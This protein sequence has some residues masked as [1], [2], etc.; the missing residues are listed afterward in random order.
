[1]SQCVHPQP[2]PLGYVR[3]PVQRPDPSLAGHECQTTVALC[4]WCGELVAEVVLTPPRG[5]PG[6]ATPP[7][8]LLRTIGRP[9]LRGGEQGGQD[10]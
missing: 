1:M 2:S 7:T 10:G 4:S 9:E 8:V 6:M 3:G 5:G